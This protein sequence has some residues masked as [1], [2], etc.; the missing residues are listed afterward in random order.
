M[1]QKLLKAFII[2][3]FAALFTQTLY[4]Q[5][6]TFFGD[7]R[8]WALREFEKSANVVSMAS[9]NG[10]YILD[11]S[12]ITI[13]QSLWALPGATTGDWAQYMDTGPYYDSDITVVSIGGNDVLD[14][15]SDIVAYRDAF[16][17]DIW[18]AIYFNAQADAVTNTA[19]NNCETIIRYILDNDLDSKVMLND[20]APCIVIDNLPD[21]YFLIGI[22]E[23][24]SFGCSSKNA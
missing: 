9:D 18:A 4:A 5:K 13:E 10:G 12:D 22:L 3:I 19:V 6:M 16:G 21:T 14:L 8:A 11:Y 2:T 24:L 20:V 15:W 17:W 1:Y 23:T 7:S